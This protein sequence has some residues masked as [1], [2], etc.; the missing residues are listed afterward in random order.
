ME[1][2]LILMLYLVLGA[3]TA[4]HKLLGDFPPGWFEEKFSNSLIGWVPGGIE[5][6]FAIIVF[7]EL[8]IAALF[9]VALIKREFVIGAPKTYSLLGF[10]TSLILFL[11]LFFG[12]FLVQNYDNGFFDFVY[13]GTTV[14]LMRVYLGEGKS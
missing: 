6:S 7:L 9:F 12:S 2:L 14:Y 4:I 3:T 8:S 11:V 13:F 5:L 1:K 10:Y